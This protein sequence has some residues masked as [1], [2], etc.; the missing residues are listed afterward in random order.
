MKSDVLFFTSN[1]DQYNQ[2]CIFDIEMSVL[3]DQLHKLI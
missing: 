2:Y 1:N 3:I